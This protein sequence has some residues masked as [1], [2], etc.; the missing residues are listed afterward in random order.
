MNAVSKTV[1]DLYEENN[2]SKESAMRLIRACR[3]GVNWCDGNEGEAIEEVVRR[4]Y[5]GL[6]FK[7]TTELTSIYENDLPY[8]D[9]YNIFEKYDK[10]A[11][12]YWLCPD[13]KKLVISKYQENK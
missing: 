11:A 8:P 13:C 4:G 7:K 1:L 3:K 10:T 9:C 2:I 5:C 6:C 12:H